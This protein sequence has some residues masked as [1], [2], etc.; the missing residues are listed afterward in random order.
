[1]KKLTEASEIVTLPST[2]DD[3]RAGALYASRSLP[4][5]F[6]RMS[7]DKKAK[8]QCERAV[9]IA[10]GIV[11]QEVLFRELQRRK[12]EVEL[13]RKSHREKDSYDFRIG[14]DGQKTRFDVKSIAYYSDYAD[15]GR[16]PFS[17]Q[18]IIENRD[19]PGPD[20]RRFFPMLM[21][22]T[23]VAQK[24]DAYVF[25]ISE[26][27]DSRKTVIEG[28]SDHLIASF[29]YGDSLPFFTSQKLGLARE[30]AK[31]G[32]HI[33]LEY[34]ATGLFAK[35]QIEL[36]VLY[37]W[38]GKTLQDRVSLKVGTQSRLVG[39]ISVLNCISL[40]KSSYEKFAGKVIL[41]SAKNDFSETVLNSSMENVNEIP[42]E[43]LIYTP[44]DFCNLF[45]PD[46]F[47]LHYIG[48]IPK[49]EY[50][51]A[52]K[53]YPAWVW[54]IDSKSRFLNT[55][56][57]EV[58]ERDKALLN[59]LGASDRITREPTRI[60][61][62]LMKTSGFGPGAC[63]YVFPNVFRTGVKETNLFVLPQDLNSMES[64]KT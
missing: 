63:C 12:F 64:L 18:L 21:A 49:E 30:K 33:K 54:P 15:T 39:P 52:C 59:R 4:W 5:T 34:Q 40:E 51:E 31:R 56:W 3:R 9:N 25:A 37:E 57:S 32:F 8:N 61:F 2:A 23:Q 42:A 11:G 62:G 6:N 27:I 22:H 14:I 17:K 46:A 48:W 1:M 45:L 41:W 50:L 35:E 13:Q 28:R 7:K 44:S 19:Y 60:N 43:A 26:S 24:K 55:P 47:K 38:A 58:T 10:K 36:E 20:W 29:P 16:P 53:K